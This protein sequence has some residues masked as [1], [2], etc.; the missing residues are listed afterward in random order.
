MTKANADVAHLDNPHFNAIR[1]LWDEK[2]FELEMWVR[3]PLETQ[4]LLKTAFGHLTFDHNDVRVGGAI[5]THPNAHGDVA[6]IA[7]DLA[8]IYHENFY[9]SAFEGGDLDNFL[10]AFIVKFQQDLGPPHNTL[11]LGAILLEKIDLEHMTDADRNWAQRILADP[12]V[13]VWNG[14][15]C[16][17]Q[18]IYR[19]ECDGFNGAGIPEGTHLYK[20]P[21]SDEISHFNQVELTQ[22]RNFYNTTG[23]WMTLSPALQTALNERFIEQKLGAL[24]TPWTSEYSYADT[25]L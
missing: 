3:W 11:G 20:A 15:S 24:P 1:L 18:L 2:Q 5:P 14:L 23:P 9:P 13:V 16:H 19:R 22:L 6:G 7:N 21:T 12:G 17:K 25:K 4:Q 10:Q 8:K